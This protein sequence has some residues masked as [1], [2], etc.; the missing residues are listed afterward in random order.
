MN[1]SRPF[2]EER[3]WGEFRKFT[4]NE[5]STVKILKVK[6]GEA[7]SL[8]KHLH[9]KEFWRVLSGDP[10]ITLGEK[11]FV[12]K[13]GDEFEIDEGQ[14]HRIF[15]PLNDVEILEISKGEFEESDIIRIEDKYGRI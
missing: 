11:T 2:T 12:A 8:Q 4:S 14:E 5:P 1:N 6:K 7:F 9:R 15:A 3:P 10:E 13:I